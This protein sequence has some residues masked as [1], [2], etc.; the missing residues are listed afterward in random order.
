MKLKV[1]QVLLCSIFFTGCFNQQPI[2]S[3]SAIILIKTPNMKFYD[4]GF[5]SKFDNYTNVQILTA[6]KAILDLKI[7]E[8][9]VCKS[10]FEC[11]SLKEFNNKYLHSSYKENFLKELFDKNDRNIVFRDL[12]NSILIKVRKN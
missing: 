9:R 12:E 3:E 7:Y 10:I 1:Y 11:E 4:T 8:D 5:I 2:K 6:G